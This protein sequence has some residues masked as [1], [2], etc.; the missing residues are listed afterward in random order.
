MN[1]KRLLVATD[2]SDAS[3]KAIDCAVA[4]AK[5]TQSEIIL[6][7][8]FEIA[9]VDDYAKQ[10]MASNFLSRDIKRQLQEAA[11]EIETL[12]GVKANYLTK[13]GE[14]F[15]LIAEVL[16]ETKSDILFLGTH[17]VHGVQHLTGSF[18]AKTINNTHKPVWVIQKQ[19]SII[20]Y[21]NIFVYVD[22]F[23]GVALSPLTLELAK[24]YNAHLHFVFTEPNSGYAVSEMVSALEKTLASQNINYS[25]NFI[26]EEL[27][28]PKHLL[29]MAAEKTSPLII[30][31]RDGKDAD[32]HIP[33][34]TNK[35]HIEVVCLNE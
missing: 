9:D 26:S 21:E 25:L 11:T 6:L 35:H 24:L 33:V 5:Q 14:L 34:L 27:D 4:I 22:E 23:P 30:V 32:K 2:L 12:H 13:D 16:N 20:P 15:G 29:D 3:Q 28:K 10:M 18:L 31:N 17:G 19:T 1:S 8:I 7:H